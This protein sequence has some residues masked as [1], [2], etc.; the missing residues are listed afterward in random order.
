MGFR[1]LR[2]CVDTLRREGACL[3]IDDPVG[4]LGMHLLS[5]FSGIGIG[6]IFLS[7]MPWQP[8]GVTILKTLYQ[9]VNVLA[10]G[11]MVLANNLPA[12]RRDWFDWNPLFHIIDQARG[13]TP[14]DLVIKSMEKAILEKVVTYDFARLMQ[15]AKQVSCSGFGQ[16]MIERM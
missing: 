8:E 11:K 15:G 1:S 7:A 6:M 2:D 9:R 16:A 4:L 13:K 10:S 3:V 14:A 5:W 12:K